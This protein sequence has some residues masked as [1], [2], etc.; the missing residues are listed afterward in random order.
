M[1]LAANALFAQA[2][3]FPD[4]PRIETSAQVDTL[5]TPDRIYMTIVIAEK[6]T[7]GKIA[8]EE[9][10]RRMAER[11]ATVGID[12]TKQLKV[13]DLTSDFKSYFLKQQ[14]V[15]KAKSF[16]LLVHDA[17]SAAQVILALEEEGI[18]NISVERVEFSRIA[19]LRL[20]LK[21]RAVARAKQVAEAMVAPLGQRVGAAIYIAD[22]TSGPTVMFRRTAQARN[23]DTKLYDLP[24]IEFRQMTVTEEVVV[25]FRL[26]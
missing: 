18:S 14:E 23:G 19:A 25:M 9:L 22:K 3:H 11:L 24:D 10:E 7:K 20:E 8:V 21:S 5:V 26:E 1:M 4:V 17:K 16:S 12:V 2:G 15:L 6:D 13:V